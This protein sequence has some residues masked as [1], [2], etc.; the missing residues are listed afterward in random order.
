MTDQKSR[1]SNYLAP[2]FWY[3][4]TYYLFHII[5]VGVAVALGITIGKKINKGK[6]ITPLLMACVGLFAMIILGNIFVLKSRPRENIEFTNMTPQ[7]IADT[8]NLFKKEKII[9]G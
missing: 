9:T 7:Q 5:G 2:P 8:I 4:F 1:C 3:N 6:K